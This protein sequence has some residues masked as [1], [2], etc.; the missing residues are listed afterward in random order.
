M[1][2]ESIDSWDTIPIQWPRWGTG[3]HSDGIREHPETN[4]ESKANQLPDPRRGCIR[5]SVPFQSSC[6]FVRSLPFNPFPPVLCF[7]GFTSQPNKLSDK[8]FPHFPSCLPHQLYPN[9]PITGRTMSIAPFS[10]E[11]ITGNLPEFPVPTHIISLYDGPRPHRYY[12]HG[13]IWTP[14]YGTH[15]YLYLYSSI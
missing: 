4:W 3:N 1:R 11:S 7:L 6:M 2:S 15:T 10:R 14:Q 12:Q 13:L 5:V 8:K 9:H